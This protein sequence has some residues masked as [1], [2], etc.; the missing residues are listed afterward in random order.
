MTLEQT[1]SDLAR[2]AKSA[3]SSLMSLSTETKNDVLLTLAELLV[4]EKDHI[5]RENVRDLE[6]GQ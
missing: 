6:A 3:S 2:R 4:Q 5:Q 1:V